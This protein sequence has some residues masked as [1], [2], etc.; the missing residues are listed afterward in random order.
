MNSGERHD[1]L[2]RFGAAVLLAAISSGAVGHSA[3]NDQ[4]LTEKWAPA[5]WGPDD[6]A[7]SVNW[8]TP[9]TVTVAWTT[10]PTAAGRDW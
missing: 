3:V 2:H 5:A 7:G 10:G 8:T 6:K 1:N 4:P 9:A